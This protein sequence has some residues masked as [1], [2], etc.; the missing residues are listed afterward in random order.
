[1]FKWTGKIQF[2]QHEY[3]KTSLPSVS[4]LCTKQTFISSQTS[5]STT[6]A[7]ITCCIGTIRQWPSFID[8]WLGTTRQTCHNN[9]TIHNIIQLRKSSLLCL[10]AS[11]SLW[12][13]WFD[14]SAQCYIKVFWSTESATQNSTLSKQILV[15]VSE[16]VSS[17]L[18]ARQHSTS[19]VVPHK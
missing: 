13:L 10:K 18:T 12:H 2:C 1:M 5:S 6:V 4:T 17:F 7:C 11:R 9:H 19:Y 14:H 16:W 8:R 15:R 3:V